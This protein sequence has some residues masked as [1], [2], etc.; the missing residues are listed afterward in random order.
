[1]PVAPSPS[2]S[3]RLALHGFNGQRKACYLVTAVTP[4]APKLTKKVTHRLDVIDASGSMCMSM[5]EVRAMYEKT[6]VVDEWKNSGMLATLISYSSKGDVIVH[7]ARKT[8]A[9]ILTP[10]SAEVAAIRRLGTRGL[11]CISGAFDRAREFIHPGETTAVTLHSDGFAN[12]ASPS[13]EARALQRLVGVYQKEHP[14]AFV[15]TIAYGAWSDFK[16]LSSIANALSGKCLLAENVKQVH[17]ALHDTGALLAGQMTPTILAELQ[18][19]A[20]YQVFCSRSAGR[21][22]GTAGPLAI[23]GLRPEDDKV[24]YAFQKVDEATFE[25]HAQLP[26]TDAVDPQAVAAFAYAKLAEGRLNES[27]FAM[28]SLRSSELLERHGKALT[29]AALARMALELHTIATSRT[30]APMLPGRPFAPI[31]L[32]PQG[33]I[34]GFHHVR[35]QS[36]VGLFALLNQYAGDFDVDMGH[37]AEGY[38]RRGVKRLSGSWVEGRFVPPKFRMVP[39]PGTYAAC[40]GF[41]INQNTATVNVLLGRPAKLVDEADLVLREVARVPVKLTAFNNYTIV[42]DG[43]VNCPALKL[44][45]RSKKLHRTL[46]EYGVVAEATYDPM[47]DVVLDLA[48]LP[49][50]PY[51]M[52]LAVPEVFEP[53]MVCRV[54]TSLLKASL[55]KGWGGVGGSSSTYTDAQVQV[56]AEHHLTPKLNYSAPT[57]YAF[58]DSMKDAA[59]RGEVDSFPSFTIDIG[60]TSIADLGKVPSANSF[61]ERHFLVVATTADGVEVDLEPKLFLLRD[62]QNQVR[63]KV[64][65]S[66][67]K[68]TIFDGLLKPIFEDFLGLADNHAIENALAKA[69]GRTAHQERAR[70]IFDHFREAKGASAGSDARI[71][72]YEAARKEI[73]A[74]ADTL[75]ETTLSP[76]VFYVGATGLLPDGPAFDAASMLT[77]EALKQQYPELKLEKKQLEGTFF[78]LP[79]AHEPVLLAIAIETKWFSTPLGI[80]RAQMISRVEVEE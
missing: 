64:L 60:T 8:I 36:L 24:L 1:M 29:N 22:N 73:E 42:G 67:V 40:S 7:F 35:A 48:A 80:E 31:E 26:L 70:E 19:N 62:P 15:N 59:V 39:D 45:I 58:M 34:Y 4:E 10:G 57:C 30:P 78:V 65:S 13:E 76:L 61:F 20:D 25:N 43:E 18:K 55:D 9:E 33:T 49:L 46:Y 21:I 77:A 44:K 53:L 3:S 27:K 74:L 28:V 75:Y 51:D 2:P 23:S 37:L 71:E 68:P 52:A 72:H 32:G 63:R 14:G 50:V 66:R 16:L 56:L 54:L 12:D 11:T 69:F 41:R 79:G 5:A 47:V 17:K 6:L 38:R